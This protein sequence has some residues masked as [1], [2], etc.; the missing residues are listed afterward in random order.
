MKS[1]IIERASLGPFFSS[2]ISKSQN[3]W[4][5]QLRGG[6][7]GWLSPGDR[8]PWPCSQGPSV[9]LKARGGCRWAQRHQKCGLLWTPGGSDLMVTPIRLR[10]PVAGCRPPELSRASAGDCA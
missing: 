10:A 6:S 7:S 3:L 5:N 9:Q 1:Q 8:G 4:S 2:S